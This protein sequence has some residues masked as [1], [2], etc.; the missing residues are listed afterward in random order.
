MILQLTD[1]AVS[2]L[3]SNPAPTLDVFKIGSA[4][5]FVPLPTDTDIHGSLE[6]QGLIAPPSVINA[7]VVRYTISM[8]NSV[9]DF[10]W[11]EVGFFYQGQLFALAVSNVPEMKYKVGATSGNQVRLDAYLTIVGTNYNMIVDQADS[12]NQFQMASLS[13]V[14]QL[15]PSNQTG[16]NAYVI[17]GANSQQSSF[18]AYT[19][20]QGLWNFDTYQFVSGMTANVSAA[21]INSITIPLSEFLPQM[22]PTYFGEVVLE[23]TTGRL[24]SICRY[25][26]TVTTVGQT[27]VLGFDTSMALLPVVGDKVTIYVRSAESTR[28]Q[29]PIATTAALGGIIVGT[30]LT[31]AADGTCSVDI[32]ALGLVKS[33]N[34]KTPNAAGNV[35]LVAADIT[36]LATVAT[37]GRYADLIEKPVA[38]S[39]PAISLNVRG[40][41]R[42]PSNGNIVAAGDVIDLGFAPIKTVNNVSPDAGGNV[43]VSTSYV[44]PAATNSTRGGITVGPS[45]QITGAGVL[46]Y[47]LP[48][49]SI[50]VLGGV[51]QGSGISI[52]TD[53][54][55][56]ASYALP[57]ASST[58]LGGVRIGAGL[59]ING[60]GVLSAAVQTVNGASPDVNGNVAVP[61]DNTKLNRIQGVVTA[62]RYTDVYVGLR[63]AATGFP[64]D[65]GAA[66]S[67][68]ALFDSSSAG[69]INWTFTNWPA[70]GYTEVQVEL[71]NAGL[72]TTHNFPATVK[73]VLPD[74]TTT[75]SYSGALNAQRG[76]LNFQTAGK[77]FICFWSRNAG[78][79]I[80]AKVM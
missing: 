77:D 56:S 32:S 8:D 12:S 80:Y 42:L 17:S 65:V 5:N 20:R 2:I 6:F 47:S 16:P 67:M 59:T 58:V 60:A 3:A 64:I 62:L 19:D 66:N 15:P 40:G 1:Y 11:G 75:T 73:F 68:A 48:V 50:A 24:Y 27:V 78:A 63:T 9:G 43:T 37:T 13:T 72:A 33:V 7:N 54:T 38:Y 71:T 70:S 22:A 53:G 52:A 4:Y 35:T 74:G 61:S 18:L 39:L 31:V 23:F 29:I 34:N 44:L 57:T 69:T 79:D 26:K 10:Q 51:K 41:A 49:A 28:V 36:G 45:L 21:N 25:V 76:T 55:I 46:D 14:D 30:G